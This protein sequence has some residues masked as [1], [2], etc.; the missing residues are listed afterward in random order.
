MSDISPSISYKVNIHSIPGHAFAVQLHINIPSQTGHVLTLPAWIPGSYMIRDFAKNISQFHVQSDNGESLSF[1]KTDKQTWKIQPHN[2]SIV[3]QYLVYA[4]DLSVRSAYIDDEF[5]F[6]NGTSLF[7]LVEGQ[8]NSPCLVELVKP[9]DG[10]TDNWRVATTLTLDKDTQH[11]EFGH[12]QACNYAELIDH[13]VLLGNYDIIPFRTSGVNFELI[14]AGG[15]NS[16]THRLAADLSKICEHHIQFFA[17]TPPIERYL[18]LTMLSGDGFGGLEHISST[19]L[20]YDRDDLPSIADKQSMTDG[21]RTFLSLCSHE[22]FHTWQVKRIKP[23]ELFNAPLSSE[24]YT[25]QLWIYEGFTSYYDDLSLTRCTLIPAES[26]LELVG[27][28]LTRLHRNQGRFKQT[29]SESSF[30]AWTKFYQQDASAI[31][32]I[33]SYYNKG[34]VIAMCLDLLIR[35]HS[36]NK[37]S[38]DDVMRYL[39]TQHGKTKLATHK[40]VIDQILKKEM[41]LD[42]S[43]FLNSAVYTCEELQFV[44]LLK[45]VGLEVKF[46]ARTNQKDKGGKAS[47][48]N[49][50]NDF[51]ATVTALETGVKIIQVVENTAAF[52]AGLQINDQLIAINNWQVSMEKLSTQLDRYAVGESI[53][54]HI[55]RNQK[56]KSLNFVIQAAAKDTIYVEIND[57]VKARKW[58]TSPH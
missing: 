32:N 45:T 5:G 52:K 54:I 1:E 40:D 47:E 53:S 25:E 7:M 57:Q 35:Q 10:I 50:L 4:F 36:Q 12:Y 30:E 16:D 8:S 34:A 48:K 21:Y 39:W 20:L 19:A 27:Q 15:H 24:C 13:P 14:L 6:F 33:V 17:D 29:V 55:I 51:G 41:K 22:F 42:L 26:Y 37:Q 2:G 11:H 49:L 58:L 23:I 46:R 43:E 38:L 56:L 44:D 18:F 31:N 9:V 3:I 28:N